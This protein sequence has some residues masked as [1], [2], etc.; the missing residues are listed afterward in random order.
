MFI[1]DADVAADVALVFGTWTAWKDSVEKTAELY[2]KGLVPKAIFSGGVNK[3]SGVVE[4]E[5]MAAEAI[6]LGLPQEDVLVE[7]KATNTLENVLFSLKIID[8][9][10]GLQNMQAITGVVKNFHARRALMTL[11]KHAPAQIVLKAAVYIPSYCP[12]TKHDWTNSVEGRDKV[13]TELEKIRIYLA[14]GDIA[15]L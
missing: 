14:R 9:K 13:F 1:S 7:S 10:I 12:I 2:H 4:G 8:E 5:A 15:E 11:R 6:R 3:K